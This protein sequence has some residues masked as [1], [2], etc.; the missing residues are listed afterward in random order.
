[1]FLSYL[2]DTPKGI[3]VI[4]ASWLIPVTYFS[5]FLIEEW[6]TTAHAS[7]FG[8]VSEI[9]NLPWEWNVLGSLATYTPLV[10]WFA[11]ITGTVLLALGLLRKK[12]S[13]IYAARYLSMFWVL[14]VSAGFGMCVADP[15]GRTDFKD[16]FLLVLVVSYNVWCWWYLSRARV[17]EKLHKEFVFLDLH[18]S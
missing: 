14:I 12:R 10:L 3:L 2:R 4:A 18:S 1:M 7:S 11:L 6:K 5:W 16:W 17:Q 15:G 9:R 13:A 8:P